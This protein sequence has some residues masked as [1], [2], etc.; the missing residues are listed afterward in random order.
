MKRKRDRE[1]KY[2]YFGKSE[3]IIDFF[4]VVICESCF[5]EKERNIE[6]KQ[7]NP[8]SAFTFDN[9]GSRRNDARGRDE[10]L[11]KMNEARRMKGDAN[12]FGEDGGARKEK[13]GEEGG[14]STASVG[15]LN[16]GGNGMG[17]WRGRWG[18]RFTSFG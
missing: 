3:T 17:K 16:E 13:N 7:T 9:G 14:A 11:R 18:M 12:D 10:N 1:L 8:M 4:W 15:L 6:K 5:D 2:N